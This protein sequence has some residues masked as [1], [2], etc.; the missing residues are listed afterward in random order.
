MSDGALILFYTSAQPPSYPLFADVTFTDSVCSFTDP[1]IFGLFTPRQL[2]M[3]GVDGPWMGEVG[4]LLRFDGSASYGPNGAITS[5]QW[6]FGDTATASGEVASHTYAAAGTYILKLTVTDVA[7]YTNTATVP[8]FIRAVLPRL[9]VVWKNLVGVTPSGNNLSK[10]GPEDTIGW[11]AGASSK[12]WLTSGDGYVEVTASETTTH[13]MLGFSRADWKVGYDEIRHAMYPAVGG[14]AVYEAG[15]FRGTFGSY[16]PGDRLRIEIAAG[17]VRYSRNG[18]VFFISTRPPLYPIYVDASLFTPGASLN[19]VVFAGHFTNSNPTSRPSTY[20]SWV[21]D[22]IEFD[23][24]R[25]DDI[26]G[27]LT[28]GVWDFGDGSAT[29][30]GWTVTHTYSE[31]GLYTATLTVTDNEGASRKAAVSITV[32]DPPAPANLEWSNVVGLSISAGNGTTSIQK[33]TE[34][35][36]WDAGAFSRKG[37]LSG[38]GYVEFTA[39]ETSSLRM[40]GLSHV[41]HDQTAGDVEYALGLS[42]GG[43]LAVWERG[44]VKTLASYGA[45]DRLRVEVLNGIVRYRKNGVTLYATEVATSYPLYIDMSFATAAGQLTGL[46]LLGSDLNDSPVA[47]AG[48][49]YFGA[50]GRPISFDGSLSRDND[51]SIASYHWDFGDGTVAEGAQVQHTYLAPGTYPLVLTVTDDDGVASVALSAVALARPLPLA[52]IIWDSPVNV[53]V[54]GNGLAKWA[55]AGWDSSA[56]SRQLIEAGDGYVEFTVSELGTRRLL[57]LSAGNTQS[58]IE[59]VDFAMVVLEDGSLQVH[60]SGVPRS[61]LGTGAPSDRLR[62]EVAGGVV[63]Y[64]KN[65]TLLYTSTTAPVYPLRADGVLYS[66]GATITDAVISGELDAPRRLPPPVA[67]PGG[68]VFTADQI[69]RLWSPVAG[70]EVRCTLDGTEPTAASPVCATPIEIDTATTLKARAFRPNWQPSE[71]GEAIYRF[72]RGVLKAPRIAPAGGSFAAGVQA[73]LQG[74]SG[75][76]VRYTIDGTSPTD[77]SPLYLGPIDVAASMTLRA[78][79]FGAGWTSSDTAEARF[80]IGGSGDTTPPSITLLEPTNAIPVP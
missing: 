75:A 27:A 14:L 42:V 46:Q 38:H 44:H 25:S 79:S 47:N 37:I 73:T 16:E 11:N 67:S 3:P 78:R 55:A 56:V 24:T 71:I 6:D 65:G 48:G 36:N 15:Q 4:Q 5:L 17:V 53:H 62:V 20:D 7:G 57:G 49:P 59:N 22:A 8:I 32:T 35:G 2:P 50:A 1:Q 18:R 21:G 19:D 61:N 68:G 12:K 80:V 76:Q 45:G 77:V 63:R 69:V 51:G 31:P 60:E 26:D 74:P 33:V 40:L 52:E 39:T 30:S 10:N 34:S 58:K 54:E 72:E 41:D 66:T 28:S 70:A 64:E 23:G 9:D 29:A 13:R 43:S